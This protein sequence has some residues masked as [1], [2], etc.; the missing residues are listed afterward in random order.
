MAIIL[1][2][3][4]LVET[5]YSAHWSVV[6]ENRKLESVEMKAAYSSPQGILSKKDRRSWGRDLILGLFLKIKLQEI[7]KT[8]SGLFAMLF[9]EN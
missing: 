9:A 8:R 7:K 6:G 3:S 2:F 5:L 1:L 4:T